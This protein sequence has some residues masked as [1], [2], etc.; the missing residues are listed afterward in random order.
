MTGQKKEKVKI[1][2]MWRTDAD[3]KAIKG[4]I[5]FLQMFLSETVAKRL[6]S[7]VL[8]IVGLHPSYVTRLTGVSDRSVRALR[9]AVEDGEDIGTLLAK[10]SGHHKKSRLDSI[11]KQILQEL[12][13]N[14]Y[15]TRQEIADMVEEKFQIKLSVSTV[16]RFL[17]K[18]ELNDKNAV[19][20]QQRQM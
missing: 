6:V 4:I 2:E 18:T 16:G 3:I 10:K 7:L 8:I 14:N 12:E 17:K 19:P 13:H 15:H 9:E 5:D 1:K 11:E 20:Y